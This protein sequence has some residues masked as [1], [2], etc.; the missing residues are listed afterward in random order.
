MT[1]LYRHIFVL[2]YVGESVND[3]NTYVFLSDD[4][5]LKFSDFEKQ[6]SDLA[7]TA[8]HKN[9]IALNQ[10]VIKHHQVFLNS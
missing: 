3:A 7:S 4:Q 10:Y 6:I 2:V 5:I 8:A 1:K 9:A